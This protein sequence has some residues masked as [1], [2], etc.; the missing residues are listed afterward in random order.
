MLLDVAV[1]GGGPAGL[2]AALV[3]GRSRKRTALFDGGTPRNATAAYIGGF[4]TQDRIAPASFRHT[5]HEDL[6]A[7]PSV[8]LHLDTMVD[9]I[10]R[11]GA[12]FRIL[13]SG[14]EYT[15]RRVLLATGMIDEPIPLPGSRELWGT[16]LF[17]CP[18]CHGYEVADRPLAFLAPEPGEAPWVQLLRSWSRDVMLFT[19]ASVE[20]EP[21]CRVALAEASIPIE[22]RRII[23]LA[24]TGRQLTGIVVDGNVTIPRSALF[25][26]PVQRQAPVVAGLALALDDRN[27]VRVGEDDYETSIRGIH[28][29]GDLMTHY[30]GALAAAAAGSK[31]AHSINHGLTVDLV[32][33]G[34]L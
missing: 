7:Y 15:A 27:Y 10:E 28:A 25:F 6:R 9:R 12:K 26:R 8:D 34:L 11:A 22:E 1:I 3:L 14:A 4:V 13:A 23:G 24:R 18:Y 30:H 2:A 20:V 5:A 17:Q 33:Q 21:A 29:A 31:A 19:N 16:S 32:G